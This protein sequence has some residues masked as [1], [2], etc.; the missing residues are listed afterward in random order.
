MARNTASNPPPLRTGQGSVPGAAGV[1]PCPGRGGWGSAGVVARCQ[2]R[3]RA[4]EPLLLPVIPS[5]VKQ[6]GWIGLE[7]N[8][9][10]AMH[11]KTH[12]ST[13]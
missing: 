6:P 4:P 11:G 8:R 7:S 12:Q 5:V 10:S 9:A 3:R 2:L 13:S 1:S